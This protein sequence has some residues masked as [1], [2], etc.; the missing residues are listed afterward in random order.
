MG[1][2]EGGA[3]AW[4]SPFR[5]LRSSLRSSG[6]SSRPSPCASEGLRTH[7]TWFYFYKTIRGD[8]LRPRGNPIHSSAPGAALVRGPWRR[9][10]TL[11]EHP[12]AG[13]LHHRLGS[14]GGFGNR[15][16]GKGDQRRQTVSSQAAPPDKVHSHGGARRV[17]LLWKE[18]VKLFRYFSNSYP[19][20]RWLICRELTQ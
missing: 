17:C 10:G 15:G 4:Q 14:R 8:W 16:T 3:G 20:S 7:L 13:D 12:I 18:S 6:G 19:A 11:T 2:E 1:G 5:T 9:P